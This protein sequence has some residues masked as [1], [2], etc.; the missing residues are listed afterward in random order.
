M[1]NKLEWRNTR[2]FKTYDEL[3][4][5]ELSQYGLDDDG[6][7]TAI[8]TY[9]DGGVFINVGAWASSTSAIEYYI[10]LGNISHRSMDLDEV[11]AKLYDWWR[12]EHG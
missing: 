7:Q 9:D 4:T 10:D 5:D 8:L 1:M 2:R 3:T 11:E 6:R 12:A